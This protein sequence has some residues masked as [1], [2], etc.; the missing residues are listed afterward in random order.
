MRSLPSPRTC[1]VSTA[2]PATRWAVLPAA[3]SS[4]TP[5]RC[6]STSVGSHSLRQVFP[7]RHLAQVRPEPISDV[8][9]TA[10]SPRRG[11]ADELLETKKPGIDDDHKPPDERLIR[12]GKSARLFKEI[13]KKVFCAN[14]LQPCEHYRLSSH[15][16]LRPH[17]HPRSCRRLYHY[18]FSLPLTPIYPPSKAASLIGRRYGQPLLHGAVSRLSETSNSKSSPRRS[19]GQALHTLSQRTR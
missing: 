19:C 4:W 7:K 9:F 3:R 17:C 10:A 12:L 1:A 15:Q 2:R 5:R 8:W 18:T 6:R 14:S 11:P 16:S 13:R